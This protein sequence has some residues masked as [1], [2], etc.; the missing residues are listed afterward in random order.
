MAAQIGTFTGQAKTVVIAGTT[1]GFTPVPYPTGVMTSEAI[2]WNLSI[3]AAG[4]DPLWVDLD[5]DSVGNVRSIRVDVIEQFAASP[6][7]GLNPTAVLDLQFPNL[8]TGVTCTI[9]Q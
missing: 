1:T 5:A 9:T 6:G 4:G 7:G 2:T 3:S 8:T